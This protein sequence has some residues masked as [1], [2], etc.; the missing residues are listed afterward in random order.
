LQLDWRCLVHSRKAASESAPANATAQEDGNAVPAMNEALSGT[1][2]KDKRVAAKAFDSMPVDS[3]S[4][5]N[6]IDESELQQQKHFE[7]RI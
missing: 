5:A 3:Q 1:R 2:T 4:V 6:E 7:Q